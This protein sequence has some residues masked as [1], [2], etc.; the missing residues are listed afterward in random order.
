MRVWGVGAGA[1]RQFQH[2]LGP[3]RKPQSLA[4]ASALLQRLM[5]VRPSQSYLRY[6]QMNERN[7]RCKNTYLGH[8]DVWLEHLPL[9]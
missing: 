8:D 2:R 5:G 9:F 7:L 4:T 3:L 6:K 1:Q